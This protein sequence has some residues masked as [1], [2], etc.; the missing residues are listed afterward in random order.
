M[1]NLTGLYTEDVWIRG[2]SKI[3]HKKYIGKAYLSW[4]QIETFNDK[5]GF[6]TGLLGEFEYLL[7]RF[8]KIEFPEMGW[9]IFGSELEA[10][11]TLRNQ[12][13]LSNIEEKVQLEYKAALVNFSAK[14]K[15]I[16][17]TIEPL[18]VFQDE[19]CYYVPEIDIIVLGYIDD[20]SKEDEQGNIRMLRDYKSKSESSKKDLHLPKKYQIEL[21]ILGLKQRG[22]VVQ[23]AE[24]CIIERLG[25][26]ECMQG[27]GREVLTV[28]DRIWYE[29]YSWTEKRLIQTHEMIVDTAKRISSLKTTYDKFFK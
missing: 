10:Y 22:L 6:N 28:G 14:E 20:R 15:K 8:C 12:K 1:L 21:Y 25:G 9:G 3:E 17:D 2:G 16:L 24:Y 29:P 4:S 23:N 5:T 11:V 27:G 18:G 19:I 13:D 7:N 26:Y